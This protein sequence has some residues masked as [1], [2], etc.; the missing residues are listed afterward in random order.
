M[1]NSDESVD[2]LD[3]VDIDIDDDN[4]SEKGNSGHHITH[5][6]FLEKFHEP[7]FQGAAEEKVFLSEDSNVGEPLHVDDFPHK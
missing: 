3:P 1:N 5:L 6:G 2:S 7:I 4:I